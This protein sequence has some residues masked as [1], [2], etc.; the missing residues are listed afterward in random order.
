MTLRTKN[1]S[2]TIRTANAALRREVDTLG[3]NMM[4]DVAKMKHECVL[5][6]FKSMERANTCNLNT[7]D[8]DGSGYPEE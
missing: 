6:G 1:E 5:T 4:E 3:V 2:A 7:K 8:T